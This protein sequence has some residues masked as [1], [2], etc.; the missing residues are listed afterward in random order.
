MSD[1][2][3]VFICTGYGIGDA[4]DIDTLEGV[5]GEYNADVCVTFEAVNAD[6]LGSIR[7]Q[8][9]DEGLN[10]VV[11]AGTSSRTYMAADLPQV[12][13]L[14]F[15][16]LLDWVVLTHNA[17]E[18]DDEDEEQECIQ[19]M[20]DDQ[21][22][23]AIT[24]AQKAKPVEL[25]PEHAD[26][27]KTIL[28]VGGGIAGLTAAYEAA[29]TG[30]EVVLVE[31]EAELGGFMAKLHR[32]VPMLPPYRE[33]ED[34]GVAAKIA[35]IGGHA[36]ITVHKG[37][38]IK[39]ING[40]PG[41][42]D[43]TLDSGVEFRAGAIVQA[44]GFTPLEPEGT[45]GYGE[46]PDVITNVQFEEMACK[47]EFKR[48][49]DGQ[50]VK[51]VAFVQCGDSRNPLDF[52]YASAIMSLNALKQALYIREADEEARAFVFFEHLRTPGQHE[53]FYRRAQEDNG[54][55]LTRGTVTH[56]EAGDPLTLDVK[57]TMLG[58]ELQVEADLLVL[59]AGMLPRAADGE[60]I[61]NLVDS[62]RIVEEGPG[63]AKFE[64][65]KVKVED[66]AAHKGTEILHLDYR[67]GP[68]LPAL[69]HG[70]P[71]SHFICFPYETRRTG[72]YA[73]GTVRSP[74]DSASAVEDAMGATL[75]AIQSVEMLSRGETV[76]PRAGDLAF[77]DFALM[78]CTQCKRCTEE[79]PFGAINEDAKGTPEYQVTRCRRCGICFGACPERIVNF[80][81]YSITAVAEAIKNVEVP[82]E[83]D[84]RPRVLVLACEN[85][86]IPA[87]E[88]AGQHGLTF[89]S[90]VRI[91]PVRCLGAV[92]VVFI[93]E[94]IS[95]GFDGVLL[96]GCK[97]GDD[98]Q[99][100]M[101]KGSEL[102]QTRG[103]NIKEA[104]E[105]MAL[106]NERVA[107]HDI[108]ITDYETIPRV[109]NEFMEL[110]DEIGMNPFKGM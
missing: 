69:K 105:Q 92:N 6:S 10:K 17:E 82:D 73:A 77:P 33:L 18:A 7:Q 20:A 58:D 14:Q 89:S 65:C 11:I 44:T 43:V 50:P 87:M 26:L 60:A 104:L 38:V 67:Q 72:I 28:V 59:N 63:N 9:A 98:Y 84:E 96:F 31:K 95:N 19:E 53:D 49:S 76:H 83:W 109:I 2:L 103:G 75:K 37:T 47:G 107:I 71:D 78:R 61:R 34:T 16:N 106:E 8:V 29:E 1:K 54:I 22:R 36:S 99:C 93:K 45:L 68:D 90:F 25:F 64:E 79:C 32:S 101:I 70:Y 12:D 30:Y 74:M 23:M 57:D 27:C 55:F 85:D 42:F 39:S 100:H 48:P 62:E 4:L 13:D 66:L 41:L 88:A 40:G 108:E 97:H 35:A 24:R 5:A 94:A 21:L 51:S 80:P 91:I 15:V 56:V 52:S 81:D 46:N 102:M 86:A 110:I 3:G